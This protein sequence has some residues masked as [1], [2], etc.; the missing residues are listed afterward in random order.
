MHA[1]LLGV[2]GLL[3]LAQLYR[4]RSDWERAVPIWEDLAG[5]GVAEAL[6]R[7]AKYHEH[8]RGDIPAALSLTDRLLVRQGAR[9][10]HVRRRQRLLV[11]VR[12]A[13]PVFQ[14]EASAK[15]VS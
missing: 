8:V 10:E 14:Q 1:S 9:P 2:T 11:Q 5:Q 4:R 12:R 15:L 7:L 13:P 6:E 3:E